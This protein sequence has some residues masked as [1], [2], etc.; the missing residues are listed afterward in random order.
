ME[1]SLEKLLPPDVMDRIESE[2]GI[3]HENFNEVVADRCAAILSTCD[4]PRWNCENENF[5][6]SKVLDFV[7]YYFGYGELC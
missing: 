4:D 7:K 3:F 5:D 2:V 1:H 6:R